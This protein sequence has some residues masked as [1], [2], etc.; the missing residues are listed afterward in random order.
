MLSDF[1]HVFSNVGYIN[2]GLLYFWVVSCKHWRYSCQL[3]REPLVKKLGVPR[4]FGIHYA[5]SLCLCMVGMLSACYHVCPNRSNFQFDTA[6]MYVIAVL[7]MFKLYQQRHID[8][9]ASAN[10][11]FLFLAFAIL[12]G[13]IGGLFSFTWFWV[14]SSLTH[15][16]GCLCMSCYVYY[17]G[18]Y[19]FVKTFGSVFSPGGTRLFVSWLVRQGRDWRYWRQLK[20]QFTTR[21]A[22]VLIAN[23]SNWALLLFGVIVRP[24]DYDTYLLGVF[25]LNLV[26]YVLFYLCMKRGYNEHIGPEIKLTFLF[27]I[28]I[29]SC[30]IYVFFQRTT[31]WSDTPARSRDLNQH[32]ILGGFYDWHDVWH[33]LSSLALFTSFYLILIIDQDLE[34]TPRDLIAV[35]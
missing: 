30:A 23:L 20:S 32:C 12:F 6:F 31:D 29:W 28:F 27:L 17:M 15:F 35:F 16:L 13:V 19:S 9:T 2:F 24:R 3:E 33:F 1:N 26:V 10:A 25:L 11:A 22:L 4:C 7:L 5:L 34:F 18:R 14:V 8:I 21:V